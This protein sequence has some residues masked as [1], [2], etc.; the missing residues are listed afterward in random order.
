MVVKRP[1]SS[2]YA[3][4][5]QLVAKS[6]RAIPRLRSQSSRCAPSIVVATC[7]WFDHVYRACPLSIEPVFQGRFKKRRARR[8]SNQCFSIA[9][10]IT[11]LGGRYPDEI[12]DRSARCSRLRMSCGHIIPWTL[13]VQYTI[14]KHLSDHQ[15]SHHLSGEI[16]AGMP[17]QR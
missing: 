1:H 10:L 16:F 4:F 3:R 9:H 8:G 7:W 17:P 5:F 15:G 13:T 2:P 6:A 12:L 11:G 14:R